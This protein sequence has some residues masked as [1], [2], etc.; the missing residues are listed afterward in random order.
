MTDFVFPNKNFTAYEPRGFFT[1]YK[2]ILNKCKLYDVNVH[3]LRHTFTTRS[4]ERGVD[5]KTLS[6]IL[7]HARPSITLNRYGSS[8]LP[9]I[10]VG[11]LNLPLYCSIKTFAG[12][13]QNCG[14]KEHFNF[15][16]ISFVKNSNFQPYSYCGQIFLK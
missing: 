9:T 16:K 13:G 10:T 8:F 4:L 11:K 14:Q 5:I 15:L 7:G 12:C 6:K 1:K 2:E 3:T